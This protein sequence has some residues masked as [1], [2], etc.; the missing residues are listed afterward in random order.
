MRERWIVVDIIKSQTFV[1]IMGAWHTSKNWDPVKEKLES[2][3]HNVIAPDLP[4]HGNDPSPLKD[5]N[6]ESY[7]RF[8]VEILEQQDEPVILVGHSLGGAI[9]C[10]AAEYRPEKVKK[11]VVLSGMLLSDGQ[12]A[13]GLDHGVCPTDWM[14]MSEAGFLS[15]TPDYKVSYLNPKVVKDLIY[16]FLTD[17]EFGPLAMQL[18]GESMAAQSQQVKLGINYATVSKVYI[19]T[20]KD[21][22]IPLEVQGK[23]IAT[24]GVEQEYAIDTGH[25]SFYT[26]PQELSDIL[27]E[28]AANSRIVLET[29]L[30]KPELKQLG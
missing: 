2:L 5:Q 16:S 21:E 26:A 4:G 24:V 25:D 30:E 20:L 27:D 3:G 28:I 22:M 8:I 23:M 15:F 11:L 7:A 19:K 10:Q 18:C 9:A 29:E 17:E 12:S 13:S 14:A 6:L 1:L